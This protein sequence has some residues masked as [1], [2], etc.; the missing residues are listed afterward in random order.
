MYIDESFD[1][2]FRFE[3][4]FISNVSGSQVYYCILLLCYQLCGVLSATRSL[5]EV[6]IM[7]LVSNRLMY[8]V[9]REG[10]S[11]GASI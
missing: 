5:Q 10:R 6:N 3:D 8:D 11:D 9:K 2:A 1:R 4:I 7:R